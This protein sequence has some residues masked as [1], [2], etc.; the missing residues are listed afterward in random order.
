M[1]LV[2]TYSLL[3]GYYSTQF[4]LAKVVVIPKPNKTAEQKKTASGWRPIALL[5][6]IGKVIETVV[7]QRITAAAED[8]GLLL[9]G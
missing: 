5:S 7:S 3:L 2:A 6:T 1:A 4:R 9:D 8:R